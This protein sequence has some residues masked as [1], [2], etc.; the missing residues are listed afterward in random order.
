MR[1]MSVFV[2]IAYFIAS[3]FPDVAGIFVSQA[4]KLYWIPYQYRDM[5]GK[6]QGVPYQS[7]IFGVTFGVVAYLTAEQHRKPGGEDVLAFILISCLI[8]IILQ[9]GGVFI[10]P[11]LAVMHISFLLFYR[12]ISALFLALVAW[13]G[14]KIPLGGLGVFLTALI[15]LISAIPGLLGLTLPISVDV[16]WFTIIGTFMGFFGA[17]S[18]S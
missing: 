17:F 10:A 6:L 11:T 1:L 15:G 9:Y 12:T 4:S 3:L 7:L 8:F 5:I 13:K 2:L 16:Y 14:L 18:R